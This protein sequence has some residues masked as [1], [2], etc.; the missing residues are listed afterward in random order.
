[1][2]ITTEIDR[3]VDR[4]PGRLYTDYNI[5]K[6]LYRRGL[7]TIDR[8]VAISGRS[9]HTIYYNMQILEEL[10]FVTKTGRGVNAEPWRYTLAPEPKTE[11]IAAALDD[12]RGFS[13]DCWSWYQAQ[14]KKRKELAY[15]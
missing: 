5:L 6:S 13:K 15:V 14:K 3:L 9:Y 4:L 7:V 10:G 12:M 11:E 1:M 2:T 8:M